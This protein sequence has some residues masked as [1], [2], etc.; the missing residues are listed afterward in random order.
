MQ[1]GS[2][3]DQL[4]GVGVESL[5]LWALNVQTPNEFQPLSG[6]LPQ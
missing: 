1:P 2:R 3:N 6:S 5:H 4:V